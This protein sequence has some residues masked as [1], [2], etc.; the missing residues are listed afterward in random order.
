MK[1]CLLML[2]CWMPSTLLAQAN[3]VVSGPERVLPGDLVILDASESLADDLE[4]TLVNSDKQ[5]LVFE[6]ETKLVFATGEPGNYIFFL[7]VSLSDAGGSKVSV[8]QHT[9][10]VGQPKPD[11]GPE[12]NPPNPPKPEP[13]LEGLARDAYDIVAGLEYLPGEPQQFA[14]VFRQVADR[15]AQESWDVRRI[16]EETITAI[17]SEITSESTRARWNGFNVWFVSQM[18][19]RTTEDEV[20][21]ALRAIAEGL[22]VFPTNRIQRQTQ[23]DKS[24][25]GTVRELRDRL[26]SIEQ[27]VGP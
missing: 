3:A 24:L 1:I 13:E 17:R 4:W 27:E 5:F 26:R 12:P 14:R 25:Q 11:P 22:D 8:A 6:R 7:A 21:S 18:Q 2:A 23:T 20:R 19:T 15:A 16:N 9:V 10:I